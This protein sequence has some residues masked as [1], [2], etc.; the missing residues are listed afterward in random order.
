MRK[1]LFGN[2]IVSF[3]STVDFNI[4]YFNREGNFQAQNFDF[5]GSQ[6]SSKL[7]SKIGLPADIDLELTGNYRSGYETIQGDVTGYAFLDLGI[8]K[9]IIKG[10]VMVNLGVRDVFESRIQER[11]V[12]QTTFETYDFGRRGRFFTLGI[13]YGFGKGEAMTYSGGRRH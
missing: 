4:N 5:S 3:S 7:G 12:K 2:F 13:S 6:W 11:F 8:R 10:K 9:K 1:I